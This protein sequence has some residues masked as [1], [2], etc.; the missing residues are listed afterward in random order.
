M[1]ENGI[2]EEGEF[3]EGRLNGFGILINQSGKYE[4]LFVDGKR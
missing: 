2:I 3:K 4:G 1:Y